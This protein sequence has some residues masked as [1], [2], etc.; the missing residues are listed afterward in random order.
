[1]YNLQLSALVLGKR[2]KPGFSMNTT[3]VDA[4]D[5][6]V[7]ELDEELDGEVVAFG[8]KGHAKVVGVRCAGGPG[9]LL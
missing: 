4:E 6:E 9:R 3:Q 1:M 2:W 8:K 5:E 7:Y